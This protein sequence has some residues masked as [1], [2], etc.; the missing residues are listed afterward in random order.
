MHSMHYTVKLN[1][2]DN[3]YNLFINSEANV[4]LEM[5][6]IWH[7]EDAYMKWFTDYF[8][9]CTPTIQQMGYV[10]THKWNDFRLHIPYLP[11]SRFS[12][13]MT[14]LV[15]DMDYLASTNDLHF[16]MVIKWENMPSEWARFTK[17]AFDNDLPIKVFVDSKNKTCKVI[18]TKDF[19]GMFEK[20]ME[21]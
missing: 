16:P 20:K 11:I 15:D 17:E 3:L 12:S 2:F 6:K 14:E 10:I 9:G 18:V 19:R 5:V 1:K 13:L 4:E 21:D 8:D 7:L